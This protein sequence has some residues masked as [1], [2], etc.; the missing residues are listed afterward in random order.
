[1]AFF[2][3]LF[4]WQAKSQTSCET[5]VALSDGYSQTGITTDGSQGWISA[6]GDTCGVNW[7][8]WGA[9]DYVFTY[10][11]ETAESLQFNILVNS[12]GIVSGM[13]TSCDGT[14]ISGCLGATYAQTD[15][16]IVL[17]A[18]VNAG[19]T[20]YVLVSEITG[21]IGGLNFDVTSFNATEIACPIPVDL[22]V[23]DITTKEATLSWTA[24]S[25]E[26]SWMYA[27]LESGSEIPTEATGEITE[28][29][30]SLT[31]LTPDTAYDFYV[32]AN[33]GEADGESEWAGP[34][35]FSTLIACHVPTA[36]EVTDATKTTATMSW[37]AG[38]DETEWYYVVQE[39]GPG[40]PIMASVK[41]ETPSV[42]LTDLSASTMY[43][44]YV[45]A[46]C[47]EEDGESEWAGPYYF[48]TECDVFTEFF[49][50]FESTTGRDFPV[51]WQKVGEAGDA[52]P[53]T[54]PVL[55]GSRNLYMKSSSETD[56]AVVA[57]PAVSN[58]SAGTHQLKMKLR[59]IVPAQAGQT[60]EVGYLT[61]VAN[62]DSFVVLSSTVATSTT[63][64]EFITIPQNMPEGTVT[65]ALRTG[66]LNKN[67]VV[68][69]VSW[70]LAPTCPAPGGLNV[71]NIT[72]NSARLNWVENGSAT[73]WDIELGQE[74]FEPTGVPTLSGITENPYT[75]SAL[76]SAQSY[77]LYL[78]SN[79]GEGDTSAWV[80]PYSFTTLCDIY[81]L[82]YNQDFNEG[83]AFT[84]WTEGKDTDIAT[85]PNGSNGLWT[86]D[87][88]LGDGRIGAVSYNFYG[89][90]ANR[91]W[92]VSPTLDLSGG[93]N[94]ISFRAAIK[95]R[96]DEDEDTMKAGDEVRLL[97][98][99]DDG[100]TWETVYTFTSDN[101]PSNTGDQMVIDLST[102]DSATAKL[103]FWS[104]NGTVSPKDYFFY[105]DDFTV[106]AYATLSVNEAV[107]LD[108]ESF[109]FYPNPVQNIL[110]LQ[111]KHNI[112]T[113]VVYN[114][115]GQEVTSAAPN[116]K[117]SQLDMSHL[118]IGAYFVKVSAQGVVKTVRIIKK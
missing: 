115:L 116:Q 118:P 90:N 96:S 94:G 19:Q 68:D 2:L 70:E 63:V 64:Q 75:L 85:G 32:K 1:M 12:T 18:N 76:E 55:E 88:F 113:V 34:V 102:Y 22:T 29:T 14:T 108:D 28:N 50:D 49:E 117:K 59:A 46:N 44:F 43:E 86:N 16:T 80:G 61:D 35:S 74:G 3:I 97:I 82:P 24:G 8:L 92:L 103:A 11:A 83:A 7:R 39:S 25:D 91:D 51:C 81:T 38:G 30:I 106:D 40:Q 99:E 93:A 13:F 5:A 42:A 9:D 53:Q 52:Y 105:I 57:L 114:M 71:D 45:K 60:L 20:V 58:A 4:G 110:T 26:T 41:V 107:V 17:E 66:V 31:A 33:C 109:K 65:L 87:G 69:D 84:C 77:A 79:C 47:G 89:T 23:S 27:I 98:S 104:N 67:L 62:A 112:E 36:L 101:Q 15:G 72:V 111:A 95:A 78:R 100:I 73:T 48:A 37:T 21:A 56:R 6:P 54:S 10:T